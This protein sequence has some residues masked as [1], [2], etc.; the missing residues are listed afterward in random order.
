MDVLVVTSPFGK[1]ARGEQIT[2]KDEM[3]KALIENASDVVR[4]KL[5]AAPKPK[6]SST[7]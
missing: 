2:E 7:K 6:P 1:Y 5:P 4:V 3:D